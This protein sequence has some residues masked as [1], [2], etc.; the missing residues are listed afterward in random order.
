MIFAT[1]C[2]WFFAPGTNACGFVSASTLGWKMSAGI[3]VSHETCPA[4]STL[5]LVSPIRS[6]RFLVG[7][8]CLGQVRGQLLSSLVLS[9]LH[10]SM[11]DFGNHFLKFLHGFK[12]VLAVKNSA[13]FCPALTFIHLAPVLLAL[14]TETAS[15]SFSGPKRTLW[16]ERI[17]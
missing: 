14:P 6:A 8:T 10:E 2:A 13:P 17:R 5:G 15:L 12:L 16:H 4:S 3:L 7:L 9:V 11:S 1:F